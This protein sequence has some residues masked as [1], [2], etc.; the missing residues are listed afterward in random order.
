[1][2]LLNKTTLFR[3]QVCSKLQIFPRNSNYT[4]KCLYVISAFCNEVF[5]CYLLISITFLFLILTL[6]KELSFM[7]CLFNLTNNCLVK[8]MYKMPHLNGRNRPHQH[9]I[10]ILLMHLLKKKSNWINSMLILLLKR[11]C[12]NLNLGELFTNDLI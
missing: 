3:N 10:F 2:L 12:V 5:C 9:K 8:L 11:Q 7:I 6:G 1:M 4:D